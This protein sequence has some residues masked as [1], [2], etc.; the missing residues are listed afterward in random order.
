MWKAGV[1][2]P[3]ALDITREW[4]AGL[5]QNEDGIEVDPQVLDGLEEK[6]LAMRRELKG[7]ICLVSVVVVPF[8]PFSVCPISTNRL[9]ATKT[10][11]ACPGF[12]NRKGNKRSGVPH[13]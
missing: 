1:P 4:L 6:A 8:F 5:D 10:Y 11:F 9:W 2:I 3:D 12:R 7:E 13:Q